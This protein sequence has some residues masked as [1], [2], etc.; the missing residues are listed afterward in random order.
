[1]TPL[2]VLKV[3]VL[4]NPLIYMSE[5][6]RM[7]LTNGV[8]HMAPWAIYTALVAWSVVFMRLGIEG[9]KKRVLS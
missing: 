7:A 6:M 5:G 8:P 2:P 4:V 9:F 1:L 3:I